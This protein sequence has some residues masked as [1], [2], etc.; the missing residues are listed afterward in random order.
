MATKKKEAVIEEVQQE[1]PE[2][3][4][5]LGGA[6]KKAREAQKL[7]IQDVRNRLHLNANELLS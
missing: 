4:S 6:F 3:L 2:I 1:T 5:E 7:T